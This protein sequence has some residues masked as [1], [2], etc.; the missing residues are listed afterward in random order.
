MVDFPLETVPFFGDMLIFL[1]V[2][3]HRLHVSHGMARVHCQKGPCCRQFATV[4]GS[5]PFY[6][7]SLKLTFS[8]LKMDGWKMNFLL[9]RPLFRGYVSFREG[10][11]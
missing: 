3:F 11:L 8:A 5:N 6:I 2:C 4:D 10:I 7:P 9:E 1:G